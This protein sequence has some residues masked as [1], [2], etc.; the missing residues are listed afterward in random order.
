MTNDNSNVISMK[1]PED[2]TGG[3]FPRLPGESVEKWEKRFLKTLPEDKLKQLF[4]TRAKA[5]KDVSAQLAFIKQ[6]L[7]RRGITNVK[8]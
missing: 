4:A 1:K 7:N 3:E 8:Q 2:N 5:F 6:E